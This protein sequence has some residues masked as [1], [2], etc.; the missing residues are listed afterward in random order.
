MCKAITHTSSLHAGSISE[1]SRKTD[2]SRGWT[3]LELG[4]LA[5]RHDLP[6]GV[7]PAVEIIKFKE[8][9]DFGFQSRLIHTSRMYCP[10]AGDIRSQVSV[11]SKAGRSYVS[12]LV[13]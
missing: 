6:S 11:R 8:M 2:A 3:G 4:R 13:G 1:G 9:K 5:R 10:G 7:K 12:N